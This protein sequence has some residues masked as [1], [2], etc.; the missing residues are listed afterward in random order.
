VPAGYL[1]GVADQPDAIL[2][3]GKPGTLRGIRFQLVEEAG[4]TTAAS[5]SSCEVDSGVE[6]GVRAGSGIVV[7]SSGTITARDESTKGSPVN[8]TS[9]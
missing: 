6:E 9:V 2:C 4:G 7:L 8:N 1:N 3:T 5:T